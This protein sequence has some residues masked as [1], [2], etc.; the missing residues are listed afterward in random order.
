MKQEFEKQDQSVPFNS[1]EFLSSL[2]L[3]QRSSDSAADCPFRP[4]GNV[5][6]C[7]RY[8]RAT[9][10]LESVKSKIYTQIIEEEEDDEDTNLPIELL[11]LLRFLS[12]TKLS[13]L[14]LMDGTGG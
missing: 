2:F 1:P 4:G 9:F 6:E 7:V 12:T 13:L 10:E 8:E 11:L 5:D 14:C 3:L